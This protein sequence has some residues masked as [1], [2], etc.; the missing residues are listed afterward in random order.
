MEHSEVTAKTRKRVLSVDVFRGFTIFLMLF[1]NHTAGYRDMPFVTTMLGSAPVSAFKHASSNSTSS[2]AIYEQ[3]NTSVVYY[4]GDVLSYNTADNK[5]DIVVYDKNNKDDDKTTLTVAQSVSVATPKTLR[6]SA[7]VI[8]KVDTGTKTP[9]R[10]QDPG[11]GCTLCDWVAPFF[12]F[13]VGV[14][15]P[16]SWRKRRN[17]GWWKHVFS[18]TFWLIAAGILYMSLSL[19]LS[20]WWGILQAIGIAYL[21]G[22]LVVGFSWKPRILIIIIAGLAHVLLVRY[23]PW[24]TH[25]GEYGAKAFKI[26]N[27]QGDMLLPLNIHCTPWGSLGFG[28]CTMA[29]TLLGDVIISS[30]R[31]KIILTCLLMGIFFSFAGYMLSYYQPIHKGV[32]S[33]AYA[34]WASGMAS[35]VFLFFYIVVDIWGLVAW[36]P[37]FTV[38]GANALL[39]FFLQQIRIPFKSLGLWTYFTGHSGWDGVLWG[40]IFVFMCWCITLYC[41]KKNWFWKF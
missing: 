36:T 12:V 39:A 27:L 31:R 35:F 22:A 26:S 41:N 15:I 38:F 18:R 20:Y 14:C 19:E 3:K 1:V 25:I 13:I 21:L 34:F 33:T 10:F 24:W 17:S 32:V 23:C 29:G 16:I 2:W 8:A 7:S 30:E 9:S 28:L 11:N 5:Y 4:A 6:V 40:L 37:I